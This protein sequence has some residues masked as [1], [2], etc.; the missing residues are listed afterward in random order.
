MSPIDF[1]GQIESQKNLPDL[2]ALLES[3]E[4][5]KKNLLNSS[6]FESDKQHAKY[7]YID[8]LKLQ[9]ADSTVEKYVEDFHQDV[10][11]EILMIGSISLEEVQV[12]HLASDFIKEMHT[13]LGGGRENFLF[14]RTLIGNYKY[15]LLHLT[16]FLR[17]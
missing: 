3:L 2:Y 4:E 7:K 13:K 17:Y 8:E 5:D 16:L 14:R 10:E 11:D 12:C 15:L 9:M 1:S 6:I